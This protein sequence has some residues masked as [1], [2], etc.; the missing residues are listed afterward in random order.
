M[1]ISRIS[2]VPFYETGAVGDL[3]YREIVS[4]LIDVSDEDGHMLSVL[5][6]LGQVKPTENKQFFNYTNTWLYDTVTVTGTPT[7]TTAGVAVTVDDGTKLRKG[8]VMQTADRTLLYV[9]SVAANVATCKTLTG[10][11]AL[12][13]AQVLSIPTNATGEG[14]SNGNMK[15]RD[16]VKRSNQTQ[17]FENGLDVTDL[18]LAGKTEVEMRNGQMHYFYKLQDDAFR[19]HRMD[20]AN[21][22]LVGQFGETTDEDGNAVY[23]SRGLDNY[24]LDY[25]GVS[26]E[27]AAV[28]TVTKADFASYNRAL[29]LA[30]SPKSGM[31]VVGG[32]LNVFIDNLFDT[33]LSAGAVDRGQFGKGSNASKAVDLGI[34]EFTVYGRTFEKAV[35]PQLDHINVTA[36]TGFEYPDLGYFLPKGQIKGEGGKMLDR[37]CGRYLKFADDKYI[38]GRFHEKELGGLATVPTSR[39]NVLEFRYTSH[40][41]IEV[42]GTEHLGRFKVQ[43]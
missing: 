25:N 37:I 35:L 32:D 21:N 9:E 14:S 26:I 7:V 31:F 4:Q 2:S 6:Y 29:D 16:M 12:T 23:F 8:S 19:K 17:I 18:L 41:A 13:N 11:K 39:E 34:K 40:E 33:E 1:A 5:E 28:G 24:I 27:S 30:R 22:H 10:T 43:R 15:Q 36:I 42:N 38:N 20:I 3:E